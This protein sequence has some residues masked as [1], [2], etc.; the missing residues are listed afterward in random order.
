[1]NW[2]GIVDQKLQMTLALLSFRHLEEPNPVFFFSF[3]MSFSVKQLIVPCV[4][5]SFLCVLYLYLCTSV[6]V[7]GCEGVTVVPLSLL[8]IRNCPINNLQCLFSPLFL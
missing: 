8:E 7:R 4:L 5:N 3:L 6:P 1:M 2:W